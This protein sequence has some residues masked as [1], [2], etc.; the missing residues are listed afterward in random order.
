MP[1][2]IYCTIFDCQKAFGIFGCHT[3]QG[4]DLH[5]EQCTRAAG[6]DC[7]SNADDITG[8]DRCRQSRTESTKTGDFAIAF[9]FI[10]DHE[11]QC[12]TDSTYLQSADTKRQP[13]T[14]QKDQQDQ[15]KPPYPRINVFDDLRHHFHLRSL[16][17]LFFYSQKAAY[18]DIVRKKHFY[19]IILAGELQ[20]K[21]CKTPEKTFFQRKKKAF[22]F[23]RQKNPVK[24]NAIV[25]FCIQYFLYRLSTFSG[26]M[27][28]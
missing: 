5:P 6:C 10:L 24:S 15:R 18:S 27:S 1:F 21:L 19:Y 4:C 23:T 16:P 11:F 13:D 2:F 14:A 3:E 28:W 26:N 8:T 7:R 22:G 9:L 12:Q 17:L 20:E 25:L